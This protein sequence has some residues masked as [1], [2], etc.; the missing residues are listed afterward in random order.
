M[1]N[2][3]EFRFNLSHS[4][5]V[6]LIAISA[7]SDVGVDVE[8]AR[9]RID[10][11]A[12]AAHVFGPAEG[13]RLGAL[14]PSLA[15]REFLRRWVAHEADLKCSGVGD[16]IVAHR[17]AT[18]VSLQYGLAARNQEV[19]GLRWASLNGEFAW[20]QRSSATEDSS[21]G[22]R[23]N[24]ALNA[25]PPYLAFCAKTSIAGAR[26]SSKPDTLPETSTSSSP[27]TSHAH[28]MAYTR[29]RQALVT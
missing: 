3:R 11:V 26:S 4:G 19:W 24:T 2:R 5:S 28:A 14:V 20:S 17:D 22:A 12:L 6:A 10:A 25:A 13:R 15:R 18:V 27:E 8:L 16:P 9:D 1:A 23:Q 7:T 29:L 21:N